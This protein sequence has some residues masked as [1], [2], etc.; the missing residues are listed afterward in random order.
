MQTAIVTGGNSGLGYECAR[1]IAAASS[2]WQV[3]IASRDHAKSNEA[4]RSLAA[5]TENQYVVAMDLDLGSLA[6]VRRFAADFASDAMPPLKAIVCNAGVQIISGLTFNRDGFETTFAVNHL[7]HF[8]LVNL[9]LGQFVPPARIVIVSSGTHNPDQFR[10]AE[11]HL[12]QRQVR[13]KAATGSRRR[14][15]GPP[16]VYHIEVVQRDVCL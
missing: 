13:G 5:E 11:A 7:G 16:G 14:Y 6:S 8:L 3:V 1:A 4:A 10:H 12:F 2:Q 15:S 9:L